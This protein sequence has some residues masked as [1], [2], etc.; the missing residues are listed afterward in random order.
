MDNGEQIEQFQNKLD[1]LVDTYTE[2]F[3]LS[4]AAMIGIFV[5][6]IYELLANQNEDE[7]DELV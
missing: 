1:K 4:I 5:C 3:D 7:E 2:E 6:K